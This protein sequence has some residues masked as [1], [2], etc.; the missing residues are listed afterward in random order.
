VA[1][2]DL[3]SVMQRDKHRA[4]DP[5]R[6]EAFRTIGGCA[7]SRRRTSTRCQRP[8]GASEYIGAPRVYGG[9]SGRRHSAVFREPFVSRATPL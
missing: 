6:A 7:M 2:H 3:V 4:D 5:S 1:R 8:E 9:S